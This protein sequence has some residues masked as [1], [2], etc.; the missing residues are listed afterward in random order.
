MAAKI[1]GGHSY[2]V[3]E[4]VGQVP[5]LPSRFQADTAFCVCPPNSADSSFT[6]HPAL[7]TA[8]TSPNRTPTAREGTNVQINCQPRTAKKLSP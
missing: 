7:R 8:P 3:V 4:Q 6:T 5:E 2:L 1:S